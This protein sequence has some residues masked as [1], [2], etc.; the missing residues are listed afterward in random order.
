MIIPN[1]HYKRHSSTKSRAHGWE[2]TLRLERVVVSE[3]S[4]LGIAPCWGNR[5]TCDVGNERL[6]VGDYNVILNVETF[7]FR[8]RRPDKLGDDG[9]LLGS[10]DFESLAVEGLVA[11]TV[12][13]EI[14]SV[15]VTNTR[16][17]GSG[18]CTSAVIT[19]AS[20]L[21]CCLAGVWGIG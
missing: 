20:G 14:T 9:E 3:C 2:T 16:V 19:I 8:E 12:G 7:D 5:V 15:G 1:R 18:V 11:H 17:T 10:I 6:R 21:G 13:V 4:L